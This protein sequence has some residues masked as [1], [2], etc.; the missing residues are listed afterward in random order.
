MSRE[1]TCY[2]L[3][4]DPYLISVACFYTELS[5]SGKIW[6]KRKGLSSEK[7]ENFNRGSLCMP[8]ESTSF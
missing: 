7:A 6:A 8:S 5:I 3:Q 2:E 4:C 1:S